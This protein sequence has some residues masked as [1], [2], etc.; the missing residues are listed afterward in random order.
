MILRLDPLINRRGHLHL[1][2][3][4]TSALWC[5]YNRPSLQH[6]QQNRVATMQVCVRVCPQPVAM[7]RLTDQMAAAYAQRGV[8]TVGDNARIV[9]CPEPDLTNI[10]RLVVVKPAHST[11]PAAP[12]H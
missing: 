10:L 7:G 8:I 1:N 4:S 6:N 12:R 11:R 2:H 5:A 9:Y 3:K